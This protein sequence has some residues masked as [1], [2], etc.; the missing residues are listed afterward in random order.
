MPIKKIREDLHKKQSKYARREHEK[1]AYHEWEFE[2]NNKN[3]KTTWEKLRDRFFATKV[4]AIIS[5]AI[6]LLVITIILLSVTAFVYFQKSFFTQDNVALNI[7]APTTA[8]SNDLVEITFEYENKN[9]AALKDAEIKVQ[10]GKYFVPVKDQANFKVASLNSGVIEIGNINPF[11]KEGITIAGHFVGPENFVENIEG[12]LNYQP[13]KTSTIYSTQGKASTTITS[14]PI[15]ISFESPKEIVGG[16]S[17]DLK[18]A[19]RNTSRESIRDVKLIINYPNTFS[20]KDAEPNFTQDKVWFIDELLPQKEQE[21]N[22]QGILGG[23]VGVSQKFEAQVETQASQG[24]ITYALHEYAP[25]IVS[26]PIILSQSTGNKVVYAGDVINYTIK[27]VNDSDVPIRDAILN[28]VFEDRV[29]DFN[30]LDLDKKGFYDSKNKNIIWKASDVPALK[31]IEPRESGEVYFNIPL[32]ENLPIQDTTD[33]NFIIETK[34]SID[35]EDIPSPIRANKTILTNS[36]IVKVGTQ[37]PFIVTGKYKEGELPPRVGKETIY[38]LTIE[39]GSYNNDLKDVEISAVLPTG[40]FWKEN[41]EGEKK[42]SLSFN[43]RANTMNWKIGGITHGEGLLTPT[44]KISFDISIIPSADQIG[45]TPTLMKDIIL[46]ASD[47]FTNI[48][49]S[50]RHDKKTIYLEDEQTYDNNTVVE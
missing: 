17:L 19:C 29:L 45:K 33:T 2:E 22:L 12:N 9:R 6:I 10:F 18:I 8:D 24:N 1:T 13:E 37:V 43:E 50:K 40:V 25:T 14:S 3:N 23:D 28:V 35:S 31:L 38:T 27:F 42:N 49:I 21:F 16:S 26:A 20:F 5:G 4:K 39:V 44:Q 48:D 11:S 46:K 7:T 34:A 15:V 47:I 32:K 36:L 30:K 41:V